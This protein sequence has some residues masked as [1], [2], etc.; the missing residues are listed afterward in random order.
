MLSRGPIE[1]P[2][3]ELTFHSCHTQQQVTTGPGYE[4]FLLPPLPEPAAACGSGELKGLGSKWEQTHFCLLSLW[5][6]EPETHLDMV[7][8]GTLNEETE[9]WFKFLGWFVSE[10]VY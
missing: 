8:K 7:D 4:D 10:N 5:A 9:L 2:Q 1:A 6:S 3:G